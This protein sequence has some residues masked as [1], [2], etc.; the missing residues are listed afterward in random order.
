[1][2]FLRVRAEKNNRQGRGSPGT[3]MK[4]EDTIMAEEQKTTQATQGA[5]QETQ[6]ATESGPKNYTQEELAALVQSES[7]KRVRQALETAEKKFQARLQE[8]MTEAEK[9][10]RMNAEQK[11]KYE[12]EQAEKRLKD[13]E[14]QLTRRE[15]KAA[16]RET[17]AARG[18]PAELAEL[19][20]LSDAEQ[21]GA[22]LETL[23]K[24]FAGA[25]ERM[26]NEK[27]KGT[28]PGKGTPASGADGLEEA[29][30]KLNPGLKK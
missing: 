23:E 9:L 15:L 5:E 8:K 21:C 17:L 6:A 1:M 27:L 16:A 4:Q 11:A 10:A 26:V 25:V 20:V 3:E 12:Q 14:D 24:A 18:L 28:P 7:D 30:Y 2:P 13:R 19:L 29:F 22:S